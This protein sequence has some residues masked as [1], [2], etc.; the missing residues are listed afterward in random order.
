MMITNPDDANHKLL[1]IM[2]HD[3][4]NMAAR[5]IRHIQSD[6]TFHSFELGGYLFKKKKLYEV[7]SRNKNVIVVYGC[8]HFS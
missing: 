6:I 2:S 3:V 8:Q 7:L 4:M 5:F 1:G